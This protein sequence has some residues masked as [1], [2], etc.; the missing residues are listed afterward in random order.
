MHFEKTSSINQKSIESINHQ[1]TERGE[2]EGSGFV[3]RGAAHRDDAADA[4]E[5]RRPFVVVAGQLNG[6]FVVRQE[7]R[8]E[9]RLLVRSRGVVEREAAERRRRHVG[10]RSAR[11]SDV[12]RQHDRRR[13]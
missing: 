13:T 5:P 8:V 10:T 7:E 1:I 11:S 9:T 12:A 3:G 2:E 4:A 6:Y